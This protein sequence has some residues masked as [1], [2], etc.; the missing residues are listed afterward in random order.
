M[1]R[2]DFRKQRSAKFTAE[3]ELNDDQLEQLI[4]NKFNRAK[5]YYNAFNKR[6]EE[7]TEQD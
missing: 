4:E 6:E 5:A 2:E 3:H 1:N 7:L